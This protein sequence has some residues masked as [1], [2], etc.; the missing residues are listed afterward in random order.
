V[1]DRAENAARGRPHPVTEL[2]QQIINGLSLG[3][4]YALIALGYTMVYGILKLINFAHGEVFM[5]GA[6]A[7][8]FAAGALG[9][10]AYEARNAPFPLPFALLVLVAAMLFSAALGAA[11]EFFAYRPVR[12]AP[13]LTPLITAIGVS[14][15]LSN[16]GMLL[17]KANPRRYPPII[18][19][20]RYEIAGVIVTNIKLTIF[21]VALVLMLGLELLVQK[22]WTGRAMR[23]VSINLDAAK[24]MG[25]DT[26]RT[27]RH[28][29]AIG[30]ALAAAGGILFGLDQIMI[31]PQMGT[32]TGLKAFVAAVLG[33]IGSIPGAVVGGVLIGLAEQ[34]T[35]GYLSPDYRDAIT[36]VILILILL[37]KPE[38]LLG[39]VKQE[40]V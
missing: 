40:K 10:D 15:F 17:F 32:L 19:E 31:N 35:A 3:S 26:N 27:I 21:G 4:I 28:C 8:F 20:V 11:I 37:I 30:S 9:I 29:F 16:L 18:Q 23:A 2:V 39:V 22:T 34:L 25:I 14:L 24:L 7:G 38:G 12:K 33:G 5:A 6:Y 13:R 36:F 1:Y